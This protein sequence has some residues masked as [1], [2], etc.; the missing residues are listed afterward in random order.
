MNLWLIIFAVLAFANLVLLGMLEDQRIKDGDESKSQQKPSPFWQ[1]N[2]FFRARYSERGE[3]LKRLLIAGVC[4]QLLA[5]ILW[6][7]QQV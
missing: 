5:G 2:T 4:S 3:R 6:I 7:S 1:I